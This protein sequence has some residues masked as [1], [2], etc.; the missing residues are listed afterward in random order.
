M[1]SNAALHHQEHSSHIELVK[2]EVD[3]L[4]E[5]NTLALRSSHRLAC[6]QK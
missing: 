1:I 3:K 2:D 6:D 4:K 5:E